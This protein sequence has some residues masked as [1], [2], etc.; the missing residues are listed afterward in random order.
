MI[1]SGPA[2]PVRC[3]SLEV[4]DRDDMDRLKPFHVYLLL[5]YSALSPSS[6]TPGMGLVTQMSSC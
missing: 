3:L 6:N 5:S 2:K 4:T 1:C